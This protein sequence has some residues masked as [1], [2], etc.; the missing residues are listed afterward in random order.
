MFYKYDKEFKKIPEIDFFK[1]P[2][3]C[4]SNHWLNTI[5]LKEFSLKKR[6]YILREIN[7]AGI[8][9]RPCWRLLHNLKHFSNCP[10]MNLAEAKKLESQIISLP[11][12]PIYGDY[13]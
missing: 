12:S 9:I 1:E 6:D 8:Q 10:R 5:L 11:S 13:N 3:F 7:K 2:N 4:K